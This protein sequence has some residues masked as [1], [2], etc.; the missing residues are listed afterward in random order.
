MFLMREI[1]YATLDSFSSEDEGDVS[2][3]QVPRQ[4]THVMRAFDEFHVH[5]L[6]NNVSNGLH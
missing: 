3:A 5:G 2:G 6:F 1:L 4:D